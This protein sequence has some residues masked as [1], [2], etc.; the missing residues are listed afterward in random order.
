ML[1]HDRTVQ[2]TTAEDAA[3]DLRMQ[4]LHPAIHHF[5]EAGVVGDLD[6]GDAI[7]AQQLEGATGGQDLDAKGFEFTGEV[8]DA[9]LVGHADQRAAHGRRVVWSVI[10]GS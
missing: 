3:V 2:I 6:G 4:G 8:D 5:R 1:G 9:G 7:L 10:D